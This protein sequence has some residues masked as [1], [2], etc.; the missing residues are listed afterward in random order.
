MVG[1]W[2]LVFRGPGYPVI[3]LAWL[4]SS[5]VRC[6]G[7]GRIETAAA[8]IY[9]VLENISIAGAAEQEYHR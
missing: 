8:G 4:Q 1:Y 7:V 9:Q 5:I 2:T 6:D 3:L